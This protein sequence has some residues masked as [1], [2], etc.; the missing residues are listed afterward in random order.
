MIISLCIHY[1]NL[2]SHISEERQAFCKKILIY[3]FIVLISIL[4]NMPMCH[5]YNGTEKE[6]MYIFNI[7]KLLRYFCYGGYSYI[8]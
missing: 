7:V 2:F 3:D 6:A 8:Y 4:W 5:H 1:V